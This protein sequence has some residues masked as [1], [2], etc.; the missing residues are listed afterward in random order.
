[1]GSWAPRTSV[2]SVIYCVYLTRIKILK[3]Y[4]ELQSIV[5]FPNED[6]LIHRL[7]TYILRVQPQQTHRN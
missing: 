4:I 6:D 5:Y 2:M 1:M 3:K 7:N